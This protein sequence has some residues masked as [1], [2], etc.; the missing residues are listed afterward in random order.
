MRHPTIPWRGLEG[1]R[2]KLIQQY[3]GVELEMVWPSVIDDM[4]M[5]LDELEKIQMPEGQ[6]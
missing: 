6:D 2:E 5:L 4:P 3:F 1:F